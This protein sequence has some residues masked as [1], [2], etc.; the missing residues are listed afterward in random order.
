MTVDARCLILERMEY[1]MNGKGKIDERWAFVLLIAA[2]VVIAYWGF[3]SYDGMG[4][5]MGYHFGG[6]NYVWGILITAAIV[7]AVVW[8]LRQLK[9]EWK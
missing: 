8:F 2:I 6:L 9:G 5:E 4:W 1:I 7:W 3:L